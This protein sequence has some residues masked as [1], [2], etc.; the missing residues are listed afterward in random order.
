MGP[1]GVGRSPSPA[2]PPARLSGDVHI[3]VD[4]AIDSD[5]VKKHSRVQWVFAQCEKKK[6][7]LK[8]PNKSVG[9]CGRVGCERRAAVWGNWGCRGRLLAALAPGLLFF[10][11]ASKIKRGCRLDGHA[12]F[13]AETV[14]ILLRRP[15]L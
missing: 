14:F 9:E 1:A 10:L 3:S 4:C 11:L 15:A 8:S 6:N 12:E 5:R 13:G 2:E 7:F